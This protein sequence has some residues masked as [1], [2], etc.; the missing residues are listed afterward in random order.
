VHAAI[1]SAAVARA[2][3]RAIEVA[4]QEVVAALSG[5]GNSAIGVRN[6]QVV[7]SRPIL[8]LVKEDLSA[9]GFTLVSS[10]PAVNP[11]LALFPYRDLATAQAGYRLA[12]DLKIVLP[13]AVLV[14]VIGVVLIRH[15][16]LTRALVGLFVGLT[17]IVQGLSALVGGVAGGAREG[18]A[19]WITFGA[20]SLIAG[21]VVTATPASSLTVLAVLLGV[22]SIIMGILQIIGGFMLRRV[23]STHESLPTSQQAVP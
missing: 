18:R 21:I 12:G 2:W 7:I 16:H 5:Q 4:H 17:W 3:T 19:W 8:T 6:G 10:I 1:T 11:T 13:I 20:V 14:L 23:V 22:S 15:L 9:R